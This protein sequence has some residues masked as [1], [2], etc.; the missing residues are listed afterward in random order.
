MV[1]KVAF[2]GLAIGFVALVMHFCCVPA[3]FVTILCSFSTIMLFPYS[4]F[5]KEK[6]RLVEC[7]GTTPVVKFMSSSKESYEIQKAFQPRPTD[8]II[9]TPPKTGTTLMQ[10]M[11]HVIRTDGDMDFEDIYYVVPWLCHFGDFKQ[12]PNADHRANPRCFKSHQLPSALY[13]EKCKY[14]FTIREPTKA[15]VSFYNH[16]LNLGRFSDPG[17]E[18][19]DSMV[20]KFVKSGFNFAP[21]FEFYV[22]YWKCAHLSDM[23]LILKFEDILNKK[24]ETIQRVAAFM[25][26]ECNDALVK[27]VEELTSIDTM[28]DPAHSSKFDGSVSRKLIKKNSPDA[29][30]KKTA[31]RVTDGSHHKKYKLSEETLAVF[32]EEWD[33]VVGKETG[34]KNYEDFARKLIEKNRG[35]NKKVA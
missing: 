21:L 22:E 26:V 7:V 27:K 16:V 31:S 17:A 5:A 1:N 29:A 25:E 20:Q 35:R 14:L 18:K 3:I 13:G 19:L 15:L 8:I 24:P 34:C 32:Q 23:I 4:I 30:Q 11:C 28:R 33:K 12:D 6:D 9:A 2:S 10:L